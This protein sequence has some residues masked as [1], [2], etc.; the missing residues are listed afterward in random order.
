MKQD[1]NNFKSEN[2]KPK[3]NSKRESYM[4]KAINLIYETSKKKEKQDNKD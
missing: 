3:D 2:G 1:K 4:E